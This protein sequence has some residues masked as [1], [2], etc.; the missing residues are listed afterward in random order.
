MTSLALEPRAL[1]T[2]PNL[3]LG[4]ERRRGRE[5]S[6]LEGEAGERGG[7]S[8]VERGRSRSSGEEGEDPKVEEKLEMDEKEGVLK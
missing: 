3:T 5:R 1:R 8:W 2:R 7:E 4:T 6:C